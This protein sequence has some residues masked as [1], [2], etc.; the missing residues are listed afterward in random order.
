MAHLL[1]TS[2]SGGYATPGLLMG[3]DFI[4]TLPGSSPIRIDA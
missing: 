2:G 4:T 1:A 3:A